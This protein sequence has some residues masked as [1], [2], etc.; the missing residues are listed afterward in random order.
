MDNNPDWFAD[1]ND[2]AE[3][4]GI[5]AFKLPFL[6]R[7]TSTFCASKAGESRLNKKDNHLIL[8]QCL[9]LFY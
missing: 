4:A 5:A 9:S 8:I 3:K 2:S 7:F 6:T 1:Y